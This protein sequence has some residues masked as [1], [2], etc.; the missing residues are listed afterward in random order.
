MHEG[1]GS[2]Q[3]EGRGVYVHLQD[4]QPV[5]VSSQPLLQLAQG[6]EEEEEEGRGTGGEQ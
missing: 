3:P 5:V 2:V 6:S 1:W 4:E